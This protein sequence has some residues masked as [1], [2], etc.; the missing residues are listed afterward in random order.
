MPDESRALAKE[1]ELQVPGFR[2]EALSDVQRCDVLADEIRA[3]P[4]V[5]AVRVLEFLRKAFERMPL[6]TTPVDAAGG[7]A[8]CSR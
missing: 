2:T 7:R 8:T 3:R 6:P 1:L 4:E 5:R